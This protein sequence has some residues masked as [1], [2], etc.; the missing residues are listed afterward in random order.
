MNKNIGPAFRR[1]EQFLC[2]KGRF[3]STHGGSAN[4]ADTVS[5]FLCPVHD[6]AAGIINMI[7][8]GIHLMFTEILHFNRAESSQS[9][10]QGE[11]R[12]TNSFNFQ[13]FDQ[14]LAEMQTGCRCS[15]GS[16]MLGINSL[17]S[18]FIFFVRFSFDI[19]GQGCFSQPL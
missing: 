13:T 2:G 3:H 7:I 10:M 16:L 4:R 5:V 11:F 9:G 1:F 19:L 18:L 17:V 14:F 12:K 15:H 6:L 8:L